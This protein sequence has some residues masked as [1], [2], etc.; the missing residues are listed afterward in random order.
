MQP[1]KVGKV[2]RERAGKMQ[3][4]L[5]NHPSSGLPLCVTGITHRL[6][7]PLEIADHDRRRDAMMRRRPRSPPQHVSEG[8]VGNREMGGGVVRVRIV[9]K[10][11]DVDDELKCRSY[12]GCTAKAA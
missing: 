11:R 2:E 5:N 7:V 1:S 3:F 12:V 8:F 4:M 9:E 6:A 10:E